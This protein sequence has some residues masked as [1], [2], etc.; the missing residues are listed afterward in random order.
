VNRT[1]R[2]RLVALLVGA[3]ALLAAWLVLRPDLA[4]PQW[5]D[6]TALESWLGVEALLAVV[7]GVLAPDRQTVVVTVAFGWFLQMLHFAV[8]GDHYDGTL[9]GVGLLGEVVL[10]AAAV[11]L[12]LLARL[13]T[14]RDRARAHP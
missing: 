10:A 5:R 4:G 14:G 7:V 1:G 9:W 3:C 11:G 6:G 8:L 12:A 2:R 13:L